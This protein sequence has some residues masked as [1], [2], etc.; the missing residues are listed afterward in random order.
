MQIKNG[1]RRATSISFFQFTQ[2]IWRGSWAMFLYML[3]WVSLFYFN[4]HFTSQYHLLCVNEALN[5]IASGA[6]FQCLLRSARIHWIHS[7][8][9]ARTFIK[10]A[11]SKLNFR[12]VANETH[13]ND[14][15]F[16][17]Y[18][19]WFYGNYIND[20]KSNANDL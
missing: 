7:S 12:I 14:V 5:F 17:F 18:D 4:S 8:A 2:I 15:V 11:A 20:I 13:N 19:V 3:N 1:Q 9:Y 16:K 6:L 10:P